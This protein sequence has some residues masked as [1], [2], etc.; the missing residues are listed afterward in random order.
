MQTMIILKNNYKFSGKILEEN[1]THII[2]DEVKL[3]RTTI[4]KSSISV[5]SD[6][7]GQP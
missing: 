7:G 3:G 1:A 6:G 4:C 5:R 2:I